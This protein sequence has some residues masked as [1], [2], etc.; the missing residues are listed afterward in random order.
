MT[1]KLSSLLS[2]LAN[3]QSTAQHLPEI[4]SVLLI[5]GCAYT[6]ANF[7]W[8]LY[9]QNNDLTLAPS[10]ITDGLQSKKNNSSHLTRAISNAHLFGV[11]SNNN[12]ITTKAPITKLNLVLKG[13]L[14]AVPS[15]LASVIIARKKN[16]PEEIYTIGDRLPGNVTIKEIHAEHVI[17]DRG[18]QLET[19]RLPKEGGGQNIAYV[20]STTGTQSL[21]D[22]RNL[23][24]KDPTSFG[25]YALPIIVKE[26]G[27]QIGYRLDFQAKGDILK[28]AGLRSTD[29]IISVNGMKLDT[30]QRSISALRK[31]R[32]SNRLNL[33][34]KRN[35]TH[36]KVNLRLK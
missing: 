6:L 15:S 12:K 2:G 28:K 36:V 14:A 21:K 26:N 1:N 16:G 25:D 34:V 27:K 13:V 20:S 32:T 29:I 4:L 7:T 35:G 8:N 18:G 11:T 10:I 23:I 31:M 30:P 5:T 33:I 3:L 9:P 22:M 17:I 19:L 24:L